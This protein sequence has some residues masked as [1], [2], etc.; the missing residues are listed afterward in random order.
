MKIILSRKGFDSKNGGF[1][2][3]VLPDGKMMSLPI[4]IEGDW[5]YN[6]LTAPGMKNYAEIMEE[7]MCQ[8]IHWKQRGT[9]GSG[10]GEN[11][12]RP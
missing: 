9:H 5:S 8:P 7:T 2:S 3:P 6:D 1:P 4:P 10:F 11:C 12:T